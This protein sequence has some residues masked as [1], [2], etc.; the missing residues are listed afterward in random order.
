M[1]PPETLKQLVL[2]Q[3]PDAILQLQD[4]TGTQDHYQ[5][6]V[7]S[8]AFEGLTQ[9]K[10]HRLIY[11]ALGRHMGG[12]VHALALNTYTPAERE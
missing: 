8:R 9:V 12:D 10:R 6:E 5:L 1:L 7:I 2:A 11:A 4:L 3:F